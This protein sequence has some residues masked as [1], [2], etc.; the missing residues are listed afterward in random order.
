MQLLEF[1]DM[2]H[3]PKNLLIR[4]VRHNSPPEKRALAKAKAEALMEEF[5]FSQALYRLL[6]K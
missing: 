4:A 2:E 1:V 3:S 6:Y 5:G